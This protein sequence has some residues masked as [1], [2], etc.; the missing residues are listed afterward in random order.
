MRQVNNPRRFRLEPARSG[1]LRASLFLAV[2]A[3]L[4]GCNSEAKVSE[5]VARPVKVAVLGDAAHGRTLTYSGV[6][7]PR[8]ESAVGFE[9][10]EDD[11]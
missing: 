11:G 8:I 4:A 6:V 2:A 9:I 5:E 7:R 1:W 3:I 10:D